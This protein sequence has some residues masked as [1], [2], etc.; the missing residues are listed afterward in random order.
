MVAGG[1]ERDGGIRKEAGEGEGRVGQQ[2]V[3]AGA[4]TEMGSERKVTEHGH[5]RQSW[6]RTVILCS[7][8]WAAW[9]ATV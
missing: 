9:S 5:Q 1:G 6:A 8:H 4:G 3:T 2:G 7:L